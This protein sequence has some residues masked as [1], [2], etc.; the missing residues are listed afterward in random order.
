MTERIIVPEAMVNIME[1]RMKDVIRR[2]VGED[3]NEFA[4][5]MANNDGHFASVQRI[6]ILG[7]FQRCLENLNINNDIFSAY[8][9]S[10]EIVEALEVSVKTLQYVNAHLELSNNMIIDTLCSALEYIIWETEL[11]VGVVNPC[12]DSEIQDYNNDINNS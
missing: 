1:S 7:D 11:L 5:M 12:S 9:I 10:R 2:H 6:L 3:H 8:V 4:E